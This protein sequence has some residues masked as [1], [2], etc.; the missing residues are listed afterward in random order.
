MEG[1]EI[2][3]RGWGWEGDVWDVECG[4]VV[5]GLEVEDGE[6]IVWVVGVVVERDDEGKV[7]GGNV[8][9]GLWWVESE[10]RFCCVKKGRW[11]N[12][13]EGER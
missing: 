4:L 1:G 12:W 8:V 11:W 6:G 9:R 2:G 5:V 10:V 3:G 13:K 7:V